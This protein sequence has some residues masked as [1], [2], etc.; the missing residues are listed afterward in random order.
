MPNTY[1]TQP[2][3]L[4]EGY[5][6]PI[7]LLAPFPICSYTPR[8]PCPYVKT[9]TQS[10][11]STCDNICLPDMCKLFS[12]LDRITSAL[13]RGNPVPAPLPAIAQTPYANDT[14]AGIAGIK[15][16]DKY[17]DLQGNIQTRI[18]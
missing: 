4:G 12:N 8:L 2:Y 16:G 10:M 3:S 15:I 11:V 1:P 13:E 14:L 17:F 5:I 9:F 7:T 6:N 18:C